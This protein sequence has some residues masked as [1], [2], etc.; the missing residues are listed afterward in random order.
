MSI[1][2][3]TAAAIAGITILESIA[4][5]TGI[6]GALLMPVVAVIAGLAGYQYAVVK[7]K[8]EA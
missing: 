2:G 1:D 5:L 3:D 8:Q 7:S 4:L 6:D